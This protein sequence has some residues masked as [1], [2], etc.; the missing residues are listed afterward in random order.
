LLEHTEQRAIQDEDEISLV[1]IIRFFSRNGKFLILTTLG[2]SAI[3]IALSLL[4]PKQYQKQLTLL[5]KSV[6]FALST[7]LNPEQSLSVDL[8]INQAATLALALLQSQPPNQITASSKFN[9]ALKNN[10]PSQPID[11]ALKSANPNA[12]KTAGPK[13]LSKLNSGFQ[14]TVEAT[15]QANLIRIEQ[16][17][18]RSKRLLTEMEKQIAQAPKDA[19]PTAPNP[20]LLALEQQRSRYIESIASLDFDKQN[21]LQAQKNPA[22]FSSRV[23]WVQILAESQVRQSR[24]PMMLVLLAVIASFMVAVLAAIIRDQIT[25]LQGETSKQKIVSSKNV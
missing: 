24:S 6:P 22:E 3:A 1:D 18:N 2:L 16:E 4:Q 10:V 5:V 7:P 23:I 17:L 9:T 20:R 15:V 14:K 21:L 11:L 12:L 19:S 25:R 13:I 8:D